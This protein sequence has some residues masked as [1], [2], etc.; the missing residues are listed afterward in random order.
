[1]KEKYVVDEQDLE[2]YRQ[3]VST[4]LKAFEV[5]LCEHLE[6]MSKISLENVKKKFI[7]LDLSDGNTHPVS[8][9]SA[10]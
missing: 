2:E 4:S 10:R 9:Y 3:R 8:G 1:M 5:E 6:N 7:N